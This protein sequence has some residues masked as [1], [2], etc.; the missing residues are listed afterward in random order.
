MEAIKLIVGIGKPLVGQMLLFDGEEM[1]FDLIR[2]SRDPSCPTC[3]G[4]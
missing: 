4:V 1:V 3:R 2:V